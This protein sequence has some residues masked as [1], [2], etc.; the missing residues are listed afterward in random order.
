MSAWVPVRLLSGPFKRLEND[1][2]FEPHPTG[3]KVIFDI[4]FAFKSR[5]LDLVLAANFDRAV[6]KLIGCFEARAEALYPKAQSIE[7]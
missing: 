7:A 4:D 5:M 2:R 1:W 3:C 6:D